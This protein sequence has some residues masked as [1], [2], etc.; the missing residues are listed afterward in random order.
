MGIRAIAHLVVLICVGCAVVL[1]LFIGLVFLS[2]TI[3]NKASGKKVSVR[4][5]EIKVRD[6][7]VDD[8]DRSNLF[9]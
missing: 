8:N 7:S 1:W 2:I 3:Y 4:R 9:L 6:N 5:H